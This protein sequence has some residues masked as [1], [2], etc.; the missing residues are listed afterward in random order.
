MGPCYIVRRVSARNLQNLLPR[1]FAVSLLLALAGADAAQAQNLPV[2]IGQPYE[3]AVAALKSK[4]IAYK[5]EASGS[6]KKIGYSSVPESVTLEFALWPKD[7]AAPPSAWESP[8]PQGKHL[9]LT[10]ILDAAPGSDARRSWVRSLETDGQHWAY[11][12]PSADAA[13]PAADRS[14]YPVAAVLQWTNPP[15]TLLFEA[16]RAAGTPPG[17]EM[18]ALDITLEN[19]HKPRRF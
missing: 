6:D 8:D 4:G 3:A 12:S 10:R 17:T 16:A 13:R 1:A 19:P 18:T 14:K 5:E 2:T 9:V 11:L 7:P 15:A